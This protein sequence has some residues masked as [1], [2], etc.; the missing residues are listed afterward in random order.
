VTQNV[1]TPAQAVRE[2]EIIAGKYRVERVLGVGGMGVVA[3]HRAGLAAVTI[4]V[5]LISTSARADE[6]GGVGQLPTPRELLGL[7]DSPYVFDVSGG[8]PKLTSGNIHFVGNGTIGYQTGHFGV[9]GEGG[10]AY[11]D[12]GSP[13]TFTTENTHA[14]GTLQGWY[15]TGSPAST[16]RLE[17]RLNGGIDYY[18]ATTISAPVANTLQ[19]FNDF[20]AL[21]IRGT[22]N[23]GFRYHLQDRLYLAVRGGGGAQYST[24]DT[25]AV[26]AGGVQ[27][28]SPDTFSERGEAHADFRWRFWPEY[29]ALRGVTEAA[30]FYL[31]S[32]ALTFSA[33]TGGKATTTVSASN[34]FQAEM[35]GRLFIDL[36]IARVLGFVPAV[37]AGF[38]YVDEQMG[39]AA[40]PSGGIG[41]FRPGG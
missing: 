7:G 5:V 12:L 3:V 35:S 15:V 16:M 30:L 1:S 37:W 18:D 38:D 22:A 8:V 9:V 11:F 21:V 28:N 34:A 29:L 32:D 31:T 33:P 24:Y 36:D 19:Q 6:P 14:H 25:T 4:A 39:T 27:F 13:Q 10:L 23:V 2:G 41:I 26:G 40:V 17:L 20:D